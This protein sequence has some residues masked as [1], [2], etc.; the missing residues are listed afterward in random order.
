MFV[1]GGREVKNESRLNTTLTYESGLFPSG[2]IDHVKLL[3]R[4]SSNN[5]QLTE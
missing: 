2:T 1:D 5:S 3:S 4:R